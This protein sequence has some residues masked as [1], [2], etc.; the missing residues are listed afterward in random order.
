VAEVQRLLHAASQGAWTL[1]TVV[2]EPKALRMHV[3]F[4]P[5]PSSGRPLTPIDLGPLL[6]RPRTAPGRGGR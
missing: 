3:A 1:H 5:G 2:F 6:R 4:G